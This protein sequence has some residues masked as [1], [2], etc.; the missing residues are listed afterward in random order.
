M[1]AARVIDGPWSA[2]A[3][4]YEAP[5]RTR[6][7]VFVYSAK[8]H[9]ELQGAQGDLVVSYC[10]NRYDLADL[11]NDDTVYFPRFARVVSR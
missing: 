3:T 5:E 6:D 9:P 7:G 11:V 2:A 1:R 8:A 4:A 10:S